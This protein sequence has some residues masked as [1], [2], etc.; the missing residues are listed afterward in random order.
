MRELCFV[1]EE[2]ITY[3]GYVVSVFGL[4]DDGYKEFA[5]TFDRP[6]ELVK[7]ADLVWLIDMLHFIR[8]YKDLHLLDKTIQKIGL[9]CTE[10]E[11]IYFWKIIIS[12][13]F[14]YF[15]YYF[16]GNDYVGKKVRITDNGIKIY[17]V[18]VSQGYRGETDGKH[19]R[20]PHTELKLCCK[21]DMDAFVYTYSI[22]DFREK[23]ITFIL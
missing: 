22:F 5:L 16:R 10:Q 7:K 12:D 18:V 11:M 19:D 6:N 21:F 1:S 17:G 20:D 15:D 3:K 9:V 23:Q 2:D 13:D 8:K 14:G 4:P